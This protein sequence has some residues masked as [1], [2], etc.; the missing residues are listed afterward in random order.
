MLEEVLSADAQQK[1]SKQTTIVNDDAPDKSLSNDTV[2]CAI[3]YSV[4]SLYFRTL[5]II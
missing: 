5:M 4:T 3:S 2:S 1:R